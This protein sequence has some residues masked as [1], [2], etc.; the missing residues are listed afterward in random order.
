MNISRPFLSDRSVRALCLVMAAGIS[1]GFLVFGDS[2]AI[3]ALGALSGLLIGVLLKVA[4]ELFSQ[5]RHLE[6]SVHQAG[7]DQKASLALVQETRSR[8]TAV[9]DRL[10]RY[11]TVLLA[12]ERR[13]LGSQAAHRGEAGGDAHRVEGRHRWPGPK[14]G[15]GPRRRA[16][17]PPPFCDRSRGHGRDSVWAKRSAA[18]P[19]TSRQRTEPSA[20]GFE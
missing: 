14:A 10:R 8:I 3:R 9:H 17:T 1:I 6:E 18:S 11:D 16:I 13:E 20:V 7:L 2:W 15:S 19:S 4:S 12:G 5:V